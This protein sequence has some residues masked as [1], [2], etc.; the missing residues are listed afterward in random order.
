MTRKPPASSSLGRALRAELADDPSAA[1]K[2]FASQA[3]SDVLPEELPELSVPDIARNLAGLWRF[4]E[5]RRGRA[6]QIAVTPADGAALDRLL[7]VQDDSPFLVDSVM[8]E[9][10]DQGL[11]VRSMVHPIVEV[12]RDRAGRRGETGVTR[13]ESMIEVLVEA[14]GSDREQALV[15][16]V[17]ET[18]A[19]VRAAVE[20]FPGM[21]ALMDRTTAAL[22]ASGKAGPDEVEFLRW[23]HAEHFVFLGARVY[24]YPRLKDGRYVPEEPVY[25]PSGGL[26]VLRDPERHVLRRANEPAV[27]M[28]QVKDRIVRDPAL[29]IAKSNVRSRVHRR[30]YMD[31]IGVKEYGPDGLPG[32]EV[33]FVGLFTA[34][35]YDQPAGSVPLVREKVA[36]V[37]ARAR[38]VPG[39]Y[40]EKRL[41]NIVENHPRDELFQISADELLAQ[42]LGIL[43]LSDRP[44]VRLFERRDPFDRFV[45]ILLYVPRDRYDSDVRRK[46][47]EILTEAYGGRQSAYYPSFNDTPLARVHY[48]IGFTPG[49][50]RNP[51]LRKLEAQIAEAARTWEDRFDAAVRAGAGDPEAVGQ[52]VA[53]YSNAFPAGY[54]DRFDAAEALADMAEL[55][56]F[57][58][59]Q[60]VRVRAY[61][62]ADDS[63]LHFRFKLYRKGAPAPLADVLPILENMGLKAM[64]EAGF[65]VTPDGTPAVWI[66]DFEIEDPRGADLVFA[67]M[68]DVFEETVA[69]VWTGQAENDG[70]NRL[71]MELAIPWRD[72]ALV[73]TLARYRQQTGLDPS[74]RVQEQALSDHPG[75][76]RLILDLFRVR[77]H[78]AVAADLKSRKAR[79]DAV[80][81]E[82]VEALQSVDSL[83]DDRV[84][85]RLAL[86]VEAIQR[87]NFYQAGP[88]GRPKPY[89]SFKVASGLLAD[90]PAPKP[91][92]EIFVWSTRVEGVHLRFGPVARGGLRWSDRRD[93]FRTEV[94]GLV[95]AQQ[96]KNAVIVP[97]GSKGGFF[98]KQLPKGGPPDSLRAEAI[99]AYKIFLYGLLDITDNLGPDGKVI[100]PK[101]MIVYDEDDP[102]LVVAADKGTAT[103]S[104]IANGVAESYGFWLGDAFAS[105]GSAGYDHKVMGITARGAWEAVKRHFRELGKDIQSEP[106]T[107][108]GCGDMSGD[109]FGNGM[110]LSRQIRLQAAFDHRHIFFDPD[111][112]PAVS[113]AERERMFALPRSSWD[114]YDRKV[115]SAGGGV[116][117][118]SLKAVP[119]SPQL[120]EFLGTPAEELPPT[121]IVRLIL[122]APAELLYLG[123][124]GTYVKAR[125]EANAD[126]GD[127]ANDA[128]RINGEDLR[129][130]VVGEGANLG[131]TQAGRIEFAEAG[132]KINTDAIDNSAGVDSSDHEVNIKIATGMLERQGKLTRRRRDAVL[133]SMTSDVA[134]HVLIHNYDQTLALSLLE[135]DA[136]GE[137]EPHARFIA[138][139]EAAGR[140]DRAVEGL[141]DALAIA[142]RL[143]AGRGLS[144]PE[145]AVLLA[146][147]KLEL[148][149]AL[150][151]GGA[152]ADPFLEQRLL[153]YFPAPMRK[154]KETIHAHRLRP[155]IVA[156][157][158]ANDM[159]NRCGP[160]FPS[161]LMAA[162]TCDAMALTAGYEAA[163]RA[164]DFD[165]LWASVEALDLEVKAGAQM[166]LFRRSVAGLRGATFWLARR[167]G[168]ERLD[169]ASLDRRYGPGFKR[170]HALLPGIL[171]PVERAAVEQRIAQLVSE[172][173][174]ED[175]ARAAAVLGPLTGAADL[176][177]LAE[178]SSW[179]L[180]NVAQLYYATGSAFAFERLRAAAGEFRAGDLFERTA[181]RRLIED[182]LAEQADLTRVVM[183]FSG[184]PQAGADARTAH[185]AVASWAALHA[186]H[187][188]AAVGA[189]E[190]IEQ[191]GGAWSFAKLTIA[192]AALRELTA[193]AV[194]KGGRRLKN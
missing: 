60:T 77:F 161:R 147:G 19:D 25:R 75:V 131:L 155:E 97:V 26:G 108:V 120:R 151:E 67:D 189:V 37:L 178:A 76:A 111:P 65:Q 117:A 136:P 93:D 135:M 34:E 33:R 152:T 71:V 187:A 92:R 86:L 116:F 104:D 99:E 191:G 149:R 156:T 10:A 119:L 193:E 129:V 148:K 41:R 177:D 133:R 143:N 43:H 167:A 90:L 54:R 53:R 46:A 157:V 114:D 36:R 164:L 56:A 122:K 123:G 44:R 140:L 4:G 102:Y 35:A 166:A 23:L 6:P 12:R 28:R 153:T 103:F 11:S 70:F 42:A 9:I 39:S 89:I 150:V 45:S 113:Y 130:K 83:D 1:A 127:K 145:L 158:V 88:D 30:G 50:H 174:P 183:T 101:G 181:L 91:F 73:R 29:T 82:I 14:V 154:W 139:L 81:D 24:E 160:S 57:T 18:L 132:G 17:E 22:E 142:E 186:Q 188:R 118:R 63:P 192:N 55:E 171:S 168:R 141:P 175:H 105:G 94:L 32:G 15:D 62:T 115:I 121:D 144:R 7:I 173:A 72:A 159:I 138:Q 21:L 126:V 38:A 59:G 96:V 172:G 49:R 125:R 58:E 27:L 128:L 170:L 47:G 184:R 48:I 68:R 146:Y 5:R 52:T 169:V 64:A 109:V 110:L 180:E 87:T 2:A 74:Q 31:Y 185:D 179:P 190:E 80:M 137:L 69:A 20:D 106:F 13:R 162:A 51:D 194:S 124:I 40:N 165:S 85:R 98:P 84:L 3:A 134:A 66:H 182:L 61:R 112:D 78:P 176:I 79:S 100:R 16:G 107:V 163:K 95:K 8:G